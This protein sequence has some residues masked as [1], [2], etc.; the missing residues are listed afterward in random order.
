MKT[1]P[2]LPFAAVALCAA[3]LLSGCARDS[4][5]AIIHTPPVV[6]QPAAS[7]TPAKKN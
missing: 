1:H 4:T 5:G 2:L 7:D 6:S 3:A